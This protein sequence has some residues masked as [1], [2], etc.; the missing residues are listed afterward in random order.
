MTSGSSA[1]K[2]REDKAAALRAQAAAG[3]SRRR[4]LIVLSA[5]AAVIALVVGVTMLVQNDKAKKKVVVA[6]GGA[7]T[8][9]IEGGFGVGTTSPK[10]TLTLFEDFYCS[11]CY[12]FENQD[13]ALLAQYVAEGKVR[14]VYHTVAILDES[15]PTNSNYSTRAANAAAAVYTAAPD[16]FQAYHDLLYINQPEEGKA[17]L[18]DAQLLDYAVQAGVD[19]AKIQDAVTGHKYSNW[20]TAQTEVASK[21]G[22]KGTP[23]VKLNGKEVAFADLAPG[24]FKALIDAALAA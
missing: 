9:L 24:K 22:L 23:T 19:K 20:V 3:E 7:P 21:A 13:R 6:A 10:V 4:V 17:A 18:T 11:A 16:K 15:D 14:L 5:V 2:A 12:T 1:R 8:G